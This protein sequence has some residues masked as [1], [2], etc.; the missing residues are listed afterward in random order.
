MLLP[1]VVV[2][3]EEVA[4]AVAQVE[5]THSMVKEDSRVA[6]AS[7]AGM[8]AA[9]CHHLRADGT[10]TALSLSTRMVVLFVPSQTEMVSVSP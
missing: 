1:V 2:A 6:A 3:A 7:T 4:A 9:T 5:E 8:D 10:P